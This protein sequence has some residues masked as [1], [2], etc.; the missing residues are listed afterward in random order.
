M[1]NR[2]PTDGRLVT[3]GFGPI[4]T[5]RSATR[6]TV[7]GDFLKTDESQTITTLFSNALPLAKTFND[8]VTATAGNVL[9]RWNHT[10]ANGSSMSLQMYDDYSRHLDLGFVDTQNTVDLDFQHHIRAGVAE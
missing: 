3:P 5:F 8:P 9:A 1:A 6:L 4:G 7:Q 2:R 10:L